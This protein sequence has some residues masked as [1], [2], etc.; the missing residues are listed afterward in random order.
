MS[1]DFSFLDT[2]EQKRIL[3]VD[4]DRFIRGLLDKMLRM[5]GFE[6]IA[7]AE[8]GDIALEVMDEHAVD[9]MITDV[10][11]PKVNGLELLKRVRRGE[12]AAPQSLNSIVVTALE[13]EY[14]LA[15]AMALD[16]NGFIQKAF[17]A[18]TLIKRLL[19]AMS[20]SSC[21]APVFPTQM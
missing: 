17:T 4:D 3:I 6:S 16:V 20:E 21:E 2:F 5:I 12:S 13:E 11:M 15:T 1:I 10:Q 8:D 9:L 7:H 19:V 14:V 18:P